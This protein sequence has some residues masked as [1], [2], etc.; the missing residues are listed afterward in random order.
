M[1]C[2]L[3]NLLYICRNDQK[4]T[5]DGMMIRINQSIPSKIIDCS[6]D[7][8]DL[9]LHLLIKKPIKWSLNKVRHKN[10]TITTIVSAHN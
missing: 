4:S 1:K 9:S 2:Y 10:K 6:K 7:I 3:L 8:E 5:V